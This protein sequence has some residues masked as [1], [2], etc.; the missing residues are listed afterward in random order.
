MS[1]VPECRMGLPAK[2]TFCGVPVSPEMVG[3]LLRGND[4]GGNPQER[5]KYF[6]CLGNV[7]PE[8]GSLNLPQSKIINFC[9]GTPKCTMGTPSQNL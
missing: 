2:C 8:W 4:F 7:K 5:G 9:P 3:S 1:L 6:F